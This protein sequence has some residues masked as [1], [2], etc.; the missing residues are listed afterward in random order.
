[1]LNADQ[2]LKK[3]SKSLDKKIVGHGLRNQTQCSY[4]TKK[5]PKDRNNLFVI[6]N[7]FF[8]NICFIF[9]L[10]RYIKVSFLTSV[11]D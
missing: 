7:I 3:L 4:P 2:N 8:Y 1:M 6:A 5:C 11:H 10:F 9:T